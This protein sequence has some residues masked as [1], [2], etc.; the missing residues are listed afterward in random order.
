MEHPALFC[1]FV[2]GFFFNE[3]VGLISLIGVYLHR[4]CCLL[5]NPQT[6]LKRTHFP[7]VR[8][9]ETSSQSLIMI[10]QRLMSKAKLASGL[11]Y[12]TTLQ[13]KEKP[14]IQLA[15]AAQKN[16]FMGCFMI[17]IGNCLILTLRN[18]AQAQKAVLTEGLVPTSSQSHQDGA[19]GRNP[20]A[21]FKEELFT[22]RTNIN[23]ARRGRTWRGVAINP[24]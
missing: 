6:F 16:P 2:V 23:Q 5:V 12:K 9:I 13:R 8:R 4:L 3:A 18:P 24:K 19:K 7:L 14:D 22:K 1:F 11:N 15:G 17:L 21:Y 10:V 20:V